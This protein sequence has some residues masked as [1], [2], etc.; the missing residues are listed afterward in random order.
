MIAQDTA[1]FDIYGCGEISSCATGDIESI[2][3]GFGEQ[4]GRVIW[5]AS[6]LTSVTAMTRRDSR[7]VI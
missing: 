5:L 6:Y 1:Y 3:K 7:K 2:R 4:I